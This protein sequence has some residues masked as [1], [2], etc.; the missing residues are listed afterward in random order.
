MRQEQ[1]CQVQLCAR[2]LRPPGPLDGA[3]LLVELCALFL[4]PS[5]PLEG[6]PLLA[7]LGVF[8]L[9]RLNLHDR[10]AGAAGG[11]SKVQHRITLYGKH[12]H[13]R[14]CGAAPR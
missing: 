9:Q 1:R 11:I 7:E 4:R 6:A 5:G 12:E 3:P 10:R 2:L 8:L 13:I 14:L